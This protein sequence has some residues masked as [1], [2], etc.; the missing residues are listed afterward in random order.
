MSD[1]SA[2]DK[3]FCFQKCLT[4]SLRSVGLKASA[5]FCTPVLNFQTFYLKYLSWSWWEA[6]LNIQSAVWS[7]NHI[8][9]FEI[10]QLCVSVCPCKAAFSTHTWMFWKQFQSYVYCSGGPKQ[11]LELRWCRPFISGAGSVLWCAVLGKLW[12][13]YKALYMEA[14]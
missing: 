12:K 13:L 6:V 5:S 10:K 2:W 14:L 11:G 3:G 8:L 9:G 1:L 4:F 7:V